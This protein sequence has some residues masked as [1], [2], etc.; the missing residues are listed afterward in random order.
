MNSGLC[1]PSSPTTYA[2]RAKPIDAYRPR[3][4]QIE[5]PG[6]K[7]IHDIAPIGGPC[8]TIIIRNPQKIVLVII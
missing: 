5:S 2:Q 3:R 1:L 4:Y 6:S 8:Y 7:Y